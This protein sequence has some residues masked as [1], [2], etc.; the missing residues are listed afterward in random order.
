MPQVIQIRRS[1]TGLDI[2]GQ[3][4]QQAVDRYLQGGLNMAQMQDANARSMMGLGMMGANLRRQ[5]REDARLA[6]MEEGRARAMELLPTLDMNSPDL[7]KQ[8]LPLMAEAPDIAGPLISTWQNQRNFDRQMKA[9]E[10]ANARHYASMNRPQLVTYTDEYGNQRQGWATPGQQ[11]PTPLVASPQQPQAA[12][13]SVAPSAMPS[14]GQAMP[15]QRVQLDN[16]T[17]NSILEQYKNHQVQKAEQQ[18]QSNNQIAYDLMKQAGM[19]IK[20]EWDAQYGGGGQQGAGMIPAGTVIDA[21]G[22]AVNID[23][24]RARWGT[25][26]KRFINGKEYYGQAAQSPYGQVFKIGGEVPMTSAEMK[27]RKSIEKQERVEKS[28]ID[29]A[30]RITSQIEDAKRMVGE[31][32][33]GF[34]PVTGMGSFLNMIPGTTGKDLESTISTIESAI[35]RETLQEMR[36]NSPTGGAMGNVSDKDI[37]LLKSSIASLKTSQSK[38]QFLRNLQIVENHFNKVV[39][40]GG[41]KSPQPNVIRYD[42]QGRRIP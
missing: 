25:Q 12:P 35:A 17:M 4:L 32:N 6:R 37:E 13:S 40:G 26:E 30:T 7:L 33:F 10:A 18:K 29:S 34:L 3:A 19:P 31:G 36:N 38:E 16:P 20:Q 28:A 15:Q 41:V 9:Q 42:A 2:A 27:E 8:V 24:N 5:N 22:N 39:H 1:P 14:E 11:N 21:S 23:A